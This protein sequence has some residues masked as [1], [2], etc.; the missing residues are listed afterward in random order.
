[1]IERTRNTVLQWFTLTNCLYLKPTLVK[2]THCTSNHYTWHVCRVI[3]KSHQRLKRYRADKNSVIQCL[4]LSYDID[5]EPTLVKHTHCTSTYH[6]W[7][8]CRVICKSHQGLKLYRTDAKA[9]RTDWQTTELKP[10]CLPMSCNTMQDS[11]HRPLMFK[12]KCF[13]LLYPLHH[14]W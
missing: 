12:R 7:H 4:T 6:T 9:W 14:R 3:D 13:L 5:L 8:L 2:H 1:M 11:N 10:I